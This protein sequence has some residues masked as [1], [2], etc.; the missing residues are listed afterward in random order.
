MHAST[1][2]AS[3]A[4]LKPV[5]AR[6]PLS[7]THPARDHEAGEGARTVPVPVFVG[8]AAEEEA[9][10]AEETMALEVVTAALRRSEPS[11]VTVP[12]PAAAFAKTVDQ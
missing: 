5:S 4:K 8:D 7:D 10:E 2:I 6:A 1:V 3:E 11:S 9:E 12:A